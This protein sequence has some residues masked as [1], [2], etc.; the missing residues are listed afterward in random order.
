MWG[1]SEQYA[2]RGRY[3]EAEAEAT[4][5]IEIFGRLGDRFWTSWS[6]FT[7]A[8][9]RTMRHDYRG[10]ATDLGPTLREFTAIND[11]SGIALVMI[12]L[13]TSLLL[14]D[15]RDDAYRIGGA[16]RRLIAETGSHLATL[17]PVND[18][19]MIDLDT[20]DPELVALLAEGASW[21]RADA[22]ARAQALAT[23]VAEDPPTG[24]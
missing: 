9:A 12:A 8:F 22:V 2:Y 1:L 16:G 5:A 3:D 21:T 19:P 18:V 7:R 14:S 13:S 24:P 11:L 17:W 23:T 15:R 4:G 6:R 10:S 20:T